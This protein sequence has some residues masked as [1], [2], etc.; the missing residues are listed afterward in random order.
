LA[1]LRPFPRRDHLPSLGKR[2]EK[3]EAGREVRNPWKADACVDLWAQA[4]DGNSAPLIT[5]SAALAQLLLNRF[6]PFSERVIQ[7]ARFSG[8]IPPLV[9]SVSIRR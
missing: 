3:P 7:G 2:K 6:Q 9:I 5:A 8:S 4:R 1:A